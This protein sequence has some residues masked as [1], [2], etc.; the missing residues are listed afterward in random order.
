LL[1]KPGNEHDNSTSALGAS[2]I[3]ETAYSV[4][5]KINW[6]DSPIGTLEL[7]HGQRKAGNDPDPG[8][9]ATE[10]EPLMPVSVAE[11]RIRR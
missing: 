8:T 11:R 3:Q 10:K 1:A 7:D 6:D 5:L 9:A 2:F 4:L